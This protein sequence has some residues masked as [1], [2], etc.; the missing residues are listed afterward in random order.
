MYD[1]YFDFSRRPFASVPQA[2]RYFPGSTIEAARQ[3]L[4]RCVERGEGAGM[5]VGPS[6]TGKTLL[7]QVLTEQLK[8]SFQ[9]ALLAS[10]RLSTRRNL[11]QAILYE[12]GRPYHGMDEGELRLALTDYLL[13]G[14]D[15]PQGARGPCDPVTHA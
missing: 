6:G 14:D 10:G 8:D 4:A 5:V 1:A 7:C 15:C 3:T 2:D 9:V 12:L 11:F 13:A